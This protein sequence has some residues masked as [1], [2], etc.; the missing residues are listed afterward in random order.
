MDR[1]S[2]LQGLLALS[3]TS[4]LDGFN[5]QSNR[6][7][8]Q[9]YSTTTLRVVL[10]GAF[11]VV[12]RADSRWSIQVFTPLDL[13]GMH[14]FRFFGS[15]LDQT[16]KSGEITSSL[17]P[18]NFTLLPE[19]LKTDPAPPTIH[20]CLRDFTATTDLW[21]RSRYFVTID[22][23]APKN[24]TFMPPLSTVVFK[25]RENDSRYRKNEGCIPFNYILEYEVADPAKIKMAW[26]QDRKADVEFS[27]IS[28]ED[29]AAR[30]RRG[31]EDLR[32]EYFKNHDNMLMPPQCSE[33]GDKEMREKSNFCRPGDL[34]FFFGVG[35]PP[36]SQ[37]REH[38]ISFFND[39][40]LESFP[41]LKERFA[42]K[43]LG[44]PCRESCKAAGN[45]KEAYLEH[46]VPEAH[47]V[48]AYYSSVVDCHL[49]GPMVTH[50]AV[51]AA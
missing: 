2:L 6:N 23:P 11:A 35:L 17:R 10:D 12:I 31:C 8:T 27:P 41:D 29:L 1:R 47:L 9:P 5:V 51:A 22:L 28:C 44:G 48:E 40:I 45:P 38:P 33:E 43:S 36:G 42:I 7:N 26:Q 4:P 46:A 15:Q 50:P 37:G 18:Y 30:Y 32:K 25:N 24:I 49:A 21:C 14:E 39:R 34:T 19:G 3:L 16:C 20:S 13:S